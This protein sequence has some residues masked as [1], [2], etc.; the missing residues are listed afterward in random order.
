MT[1]QQQVVSPNSAD[2]FHRQCLSPS[3]QYSPTSSTTSFP[4]Q[5]IRVLLLEKVS[6]SAVKM[7]EREGFQVECQVKASEQELIERIGDYHAIGVRSKT[8]LTP[9][10]LAAAKRLLVI[11]C[12]CIGTD[13]TDL[14]A[15]ARRGVAVF[16]APFANTR[17]V[18]ELAIGE[19]I[20]LARQFTDR[21]NECHNKK[22]NKQSSNCY[23][24]RGKTL[25]IIGYGHVGSQLSV[26]AE[27]LGMRVQFY[28]VIPKL[29]LG[30]AVQRETL[31]D[32]MSDADFVSLHVPGTPETM[33][34]IGATEISW[35]Q[36][37]AFFL[38]ASRG[39]VVD[40]NA[41]KDALI[42]KHLG[43]AAIDVFPYEP[44][45]ADEPFECPLQGLPNVILTPHIGG[46]TEEAQVQI[47][48]EVASK[49]ITFINTGASIGAVNLPELSLAPHKSTHRILN[50]HS[51]VPGMLRDVNNVLAEYNVVAQLLMT[52]GPVGYLIVDVEKG[53]SQEIKQKIAAIP[54]SIRTRLL[55]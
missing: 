27:A 30:L 39:K 43:G 4:K 15:A 36:K 54:K 2:E 25:C 26:L 48:L 32:A 11:G 5:K 34:M 46:S 21:S 45:A 23:E 37:G 12:F 50:I 51:N 7:F 55:Y 52:M 33:N 17:S 41:V 49:M 10:I 14:D 8:Q 18:A 13:Q 22:W 31:K 29:S 47:G 42:N 35:M 44:A 24:L 6:P 9:A 1:S 53:V 40:L 28:D 19:M 38:N 3:S 20:A 16:N